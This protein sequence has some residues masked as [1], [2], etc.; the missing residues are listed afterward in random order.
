[1]VASPSVPTVPVPV[2][3]SLLLDVSSSEVEE[4]EVSLEVLGECRLSRL[5]I[6]SLSHWNKQDLF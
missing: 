4:V 3:V 6:T 1:M 2:M 5:I